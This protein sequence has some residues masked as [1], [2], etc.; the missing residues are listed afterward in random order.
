S[1][2]RLYGDHSCC[3]PGCFAPPDIAS[4][5]A[6]KRELSGTVHRW[7]TSAAPHTRGKQKSATDA[8]FRIALVC[9]RNSRRYQVGQSSRA[10]SKNGHR[11]ASGSW[12]DPLVERLVG[13][14]PND[15]Q[16]EGIYSQLVVLNILAEDV[17]HA[18]G[19]SL[20]LEF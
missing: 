20:T 3:Q 15:G 17:G 1:S 14:E 5:C 11:K 4:N 6:G 18:V 10:D 2:Q 16:A 12:C 7:R 9:R 8:L 13:S 19:P